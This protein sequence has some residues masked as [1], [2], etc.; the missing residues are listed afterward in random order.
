[1]RRRLVDNENVE[2]GFPLHL[3]FSPKGEK[4]IADVYVFKPEGT[5]RDDDEDDGKDRKKL[6]GI[7]S[8]RKREGV[9]F[10]RN[11]QTQG[12]LPR[13]YFKRDTLKL[14]PIAED[15]L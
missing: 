13:D 6:G 4:L 15:M 12:S 5:E 14:K 1:L 7:K 9:V 10:V 8:Y 3:N 11:G 2:D